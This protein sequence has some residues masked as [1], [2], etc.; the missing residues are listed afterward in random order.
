M[1]KKI[2]ILILI[3]S[4]LTLGFSFGSKQA[5][6][7]A[8]LYNLRIWTY[9]NSAAFNWY[10]GGSYYSELHY[11][12]TDKY[13]YK[14]DRSQL[15]DWHSYEIK[16]LF[17]GTKYY[18][19]IVLRKQLNA[20]AL[21]TVAE[22][23]FIT[24]GY[25]TPLRVFKPY[26]FL[27][28]NKDF[29]SQSYQYPAE[30]LNSTGL[31]FVQ[32]AVWQGKS[33]QVKAKNSHLTYSCQPMF[34]AG[35]GTVMAWVRL[36]KFDKDMVIWQTDDSRYALYFQHGR[37][38]NRIVARAGW[39]EK[40]SGETGQ[41]A[42]YY[43]KT[44]GN[45]KNVWQPGEWHMLAMVWQGKL[46]GTVKLYIDG[47]M[48]AKATYS[49]GGGCGSFMVGNNYRHNM[50]WSNGQIDDLKLFDWDLDSTSVRNEYKN[51][52]WNQK[53]NLSGRV[54]GAHIRWFKDGKLLKA[55]D[56]K[57]YVISRGKRL[58]ISNPSALK[59]YGS[60]SIINATWDEIGQ[61]END[62]QFTAW[63]KF[64]DGT[65][66]KVYGRPTVYWVWN[67]KAGAILNQQVF[68]KY[69][70]VWQDVVEISQNEFN[71]YPQG[72]LYK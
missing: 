14:I 30:I 53:Q 13:G 10:T 24:Q 56:G 65:L 40:R 62:G 66:L 15:A 72:P 69:G 22:G 60:H 43:F 58:H 7:K 32:P 48:R 55:P 59:R 45:N 44:S 51:Y 70:N 68:A 23:T 39:D 36:E 54:A 34:N 31:K 19:K 61:Y 1:T 21:E 50:N 18:Y 46:N 17:P 63:S 47:E 20:G 16:G 9:T 49:N 29:Y 11:G 28:F 4:L 41:E 12:T 52:Q 33:L 26:F 37:N 25:Q 3:L 64:P 6:A 2:L 8:K 35:Y 67:A 5:A 27:N 38:W 42:K 71:L 57:I